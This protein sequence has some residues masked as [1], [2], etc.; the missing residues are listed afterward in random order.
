MVLKTQKKQNNLYGY[1]ILG[2]NAIESLE[3][4]LRKDS[5]RDN[6]LPLIAKASQ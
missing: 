2:N 3:T 4:L 1:E 6:T 5:I